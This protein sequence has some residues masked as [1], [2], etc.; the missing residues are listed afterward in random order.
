MDKLPE[1]PHLYWW[2]TMEDRPATFSSAMNQEE[3]KKF[4]ESIIAS[5]PD[6]ETFERMI[7]ATN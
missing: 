5:L 7:H 2:R 6:D 4:R 1:V 3:A